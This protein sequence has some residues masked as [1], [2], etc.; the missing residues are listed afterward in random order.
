M[1]EMLLHDDFLLLVFDAIY[2]VVS[3]EFVDYE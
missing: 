3:A 1:L 2:E